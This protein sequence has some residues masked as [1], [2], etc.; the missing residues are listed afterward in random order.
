[1][2]KTENKVTV[3]KAECTSSLRNVIDAL[4]VLNGKWKLPIV[5]SLVNAPKR[6]NEIMKDLEGISPKILAQEL[7][8]LEQNELVVRNVYPTTPVSIVY[9]ASAYSETL[10]D[11]L[12]TLSHWGAGHRNKIIGK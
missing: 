5:L 12:K 10:N 11:V 7:R 4:Y 8:H 9:E 6:F 1:M 2:E 3:T